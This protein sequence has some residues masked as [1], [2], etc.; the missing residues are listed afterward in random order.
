MA[1]RAGLSFDVAKHQQR[2]ESD[3]GYDMNR[4][5]SSTTPYK[6]PVQLHGI[7]MSTLEYFAYEGVGKVLRGVTGH[8]QA[9]RSIGG[10]LPSTTDVAF[11][12]DI[13]EEIAQAFRNVETALKD[14]GGKG[15][16]QVFR[17]NSYHT[18]LT[19]EVTAIMKK[20][21]EKYMPDHA[22]I[23]TEIGVKKLGAPTMNVEIEVSAFDPEGAK[24]RT[25]A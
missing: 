23:W 10:W 15:W 9:V 4:Q 13:E 1:V 2:C 21:F 3:F 16:T 17:V 25:K 19:D 14:A 24:A 18:D 8:M 12:E 6:S 7:I 5:T 22:P 11:P 20:N